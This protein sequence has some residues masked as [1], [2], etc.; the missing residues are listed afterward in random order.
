MSPWYGSPELDEQSSGLAARG[1]RGLLVAGVLVH[2]AEAF[3][4]SGLF[5]QESQLPPQAQRVAQA[6]SGLVSALLGA[7]QLA[8][9][10]QRPRLT[11]TITVLP[12]QFQ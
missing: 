11:E 4:C 3:Q 8:E 2:V 1:L 7:V 5:P 10:L 9:T 12:A 6:V